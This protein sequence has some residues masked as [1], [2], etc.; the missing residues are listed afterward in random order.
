M[1]ME[2]VMKPM[3]LALGHGLSPSGRRSVGMWGRIRTWWS[4]ARERRRLAELDP[5]LL[6]DMG[7]SPEEAGSEAARPFW[8]INSVR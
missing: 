2:P 1:L 5:R 8:D 3:D 6:E 7:I 4:V